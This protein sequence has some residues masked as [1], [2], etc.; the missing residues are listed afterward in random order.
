[1]KLKYNLFS[2]IV[3]LLGITTIVS[4]QN[5]ADIAEAK[6]G[7]RIMLNSISSSTLTRSTPSEIGKPVADK[8]DLRVVDNASGM[9]KYDGK[10]TNE[11]IRLAGG[12]YT[13]TASCGENPIIATDAPY[14][15]GTQEVTVVQNEVTETSISCRVGNALIS[16]IFGANESDRTRFAKFYKSYGVRVKVD[17]YSVDIPSTASS[18]SAYFR[19]GST[20]E[21]EFYGVLAANDQQVN[22]V[23]TTPKE[24]ILPNPFKAADHAIVTLTLPD[25]ESATVL[26]I[27]KVELTEA[28]MEETIPLSWLPI[29]QATAEHQYDANGDLVG[30]NV[31]FTNS[32]P[33]MAWK[34]VVTD[35]DGTEYR[36]IQGTGS[37]SSTY[38][39]NA[40]GWPYLPAGNYT[41]TYYLVQ[42]GQEPQKTGSRTFTVA[43]P[44][45]K[46]TVDGY[47]SYS[48]YLEGAV[49]A[50][51]A[52]DAFTIY[53][54]SA[55]MNVSP[56]LLSN[57]KYTYS[58]TTSLNGSPL[59]GAQSGNT[60]TYNNQTEKTPSFEAY[61][62]ACS[63]TFD[64]TTATDSKNVYITGLPVTFAP[65]KQDDGWTGRGTVAWND[66]DSD[67]GN[68]PR[69]RLGQN[70]TSNPQYIEYKN[71][72]V[73]SGVK[74]EG[75]YDVA[76][77]PATENVTLTLSFGD[78]KYFDVT[79]KKM[80]SFSWGEDKPYK[81]SNTFTT[82]SK[83]SS[84]K[85]N[86]SQ[87]V[88][89]NRSYIY[90]LSYKYGK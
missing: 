84:A 65:P 8:F 53:A 23:L 81:S 69:I 3:L 12:E 30:T 51:N 67:R 46:V 32:Y 74:I 68:T 54:P 85:A 18:M 78:I 63:A 72:T 76:I 22:M 20:P 75:G 43:N 64:K 17:G 11:L 37:L 24:G 44:N 7:L 50:A 90:S 2:I 9:T 80:G 77:H 48:K 57:S 29:P 33:G 41:A 87:G 47:T 31:T 56:S 4:C 60:F 39:D 59:S 6:G 45:L 89:Q 27:S 35:A 16:V 86:N 79:E 26:D 58:L 14:Y 15:I 19:A 36:T 28:T 83:V 38:S 5:E 42:D 1:M 52:C 40:E 34:A 25:P 55:K 13:V 49:D 70:V 73:P 21:L 82:T 61:T 88:A 10:M 71:F 66:K 62:I